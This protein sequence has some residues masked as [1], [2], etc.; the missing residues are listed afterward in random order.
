MDGDEI[1]VP[2]TPSTINIFGEVL[3]PIS[4]QFRD[5]VSVR[6]AISIAGGTQKFADQGRIYVIRANGEVVRLGRNIF[7]NNIDLE[8][9]DTII[10]PRKLTSSSPFLKALAPITQILSDV[11][12]SAA[13]IESLS[14]N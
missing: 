2:K 12:F 6:E 10:V 7:I 13:A 9:G 1:I 14:N 8:P 11:A 3:N 4:F 5:D